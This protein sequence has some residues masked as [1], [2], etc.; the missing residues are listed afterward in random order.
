MT[1]KGRSSSASA[2]KYLLE[3]PH[4]AGWD[5]LLHSVTDWRRILKPFVRA[6]ALIALCPVL[7]LYGQTQKKL[8]T[9]DLATREGAIVSRGITNVEWRPGGKEIS[10]IRRGGPGSIAETTLWAFDV[11]TKKVRM[12]AGSASG[13]AKLNLDSYQWSPKGDALL[14]EGSHDLWLLDAAS[15]RKT[16]LT[17]DGEEKED[18]TFSP[19][20]DRVA[21][22]KKNNLYVEEIASGAVKQLTTDGGEDVMNAKLDWVYEEELA[23]RATG[24]AYEWSPDGKKIAYLRL[25]DSPVPRYPL[26]SYLATHVQLTFERFPQSGDSNPA[27]SFHVVALDGSLR[28]T[29]AA[30]ENSAA[31]EYFGPSFA[32]TPDSSAISFLTMNRAQNQLTAHLWNPATKSSRELL[33]END[34][35]WINSLDA[36]YFLRNGQQFLWLSERDG[37]MHLYLYGLDGKLVR[38][39]TQGN[40]MIDHP[41]FSNV[42]M[43][44]VDEESGRVY[45]TSTN[46]DPRE[47]QIYRVRIDGGGGE[48]LSQ[49]HGSHSINL[50]PNGQHFIETYSSVESPPQSRIYKS[51][52]S[53]VANLDQPENHLNE[54]SLATTELVEVKAADGATLYARLVKPPDFDPIRKYPVIVSVYGG[55]HVQIIQNRWGVTS[56]M[57]HVFAQEGF[58]V[59]SLDNRGSWGRG[60]AWEAAIFRDMGRHELADQL[61]GIAYLKSLP[62]VDGNR[63]GIWGWSYGGYM[64][65]YTLTHAPDIFKCGAAGGPVTDWKFYDSIYTERYM[66]TPQQNVDGYK[67]SSPLEEAANLK[68]SILLIHGADDDNVHMQ[69][70]MNFVDALVKAG[71][72]FDLYVQPGEKHGF[73]K[74][75]DRLYLNNRLLQFFKEHLQR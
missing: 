64:T 18:V 62:Y 54:Y 44:Q 74:P 73:S 38:Q 35:T 10:Y 41:A 43:F 72:P 56:L 27:P 69:N 19:M 17:T 4:R 66:R 12:L 68:A 51:D 70:T 61:A 67:D 36:P 30:S 75:A 46:P 3:L 53:F 42:P 47:R 65:L 59:W 57:D 49:E 33:V 16:R 9:V 31:I 5:M 2:A 24:R 6:L 14:L 40:W 45:F 23:N 50:A 1:I 21:F 32:W 60:H 8:L 26:T 29:W 22:V 34:P 37:W 58:L 48:R 25:D 7:T 63:L 15:G 28:E 20:G 39:L 13:D 52:G 71:R 11:A 55:P